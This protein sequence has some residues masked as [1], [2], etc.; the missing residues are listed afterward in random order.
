MFTGIRY[1]NGVNVLTV[2]YK[3]HKRKLVKIPPGYK[4]IK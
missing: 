2:T 1:T 3:A 4:R